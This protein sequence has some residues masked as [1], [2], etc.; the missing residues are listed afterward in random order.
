[1]SGY[2]NSTSTGN[3]QISLLGQVS[4]LYPNYT[5]DDFVI[6][7]G[8]DFAIDLTT[9]YDGRPKIVSSDSPVAFGTASYS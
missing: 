5:G 8:L 9:G 4:Y 3:Y 1:M 2:V 7:Y 6:G